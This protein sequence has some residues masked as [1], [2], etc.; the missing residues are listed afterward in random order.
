M[1][2]HLTVPQV[3]SWRPEVLV[4]QAGEWDRQATDLRTRVETQWRAVDSS[5]ETWQGPSGGAMRN[6]FDGVRTKAQQVLEA[7]EDGRD[8]A[9]VASMNF[10]TAKVVLKNSVDAAKAAGFDVWDDGTCIISEKTKQSVYASVA[11]SDRSGEAYQTAIAALSVS[12]DA[13]T[14]A[15]KKALDLAAEVDTQAQTAVRNA[16]ANMPAPDSFGNATTPKT[17]PAPPPPANGS[18][19]ENRAW[20][21]SLSEHEKTSLIDTRPAS[22]GGLDGLPDAVR[23]KANRNLIPIERARIEQDLAAYNSILKTDTT[24]G[25]ARSKR[26]DLQE[27]LDDLNEVDKQVSG[28]PERK[29]LLLDMRSGLQGRAA[30]AIGDPDNADHVSVTTPGLGTNVRESLGSMIGEAQALKAESEGQLNERHAGGSVATI[31]W[32]GY[33][34]PQKTYSDLDIAGVAM[35]GRAESAAPTLANFYEGLDVASTKNDPHITALGHSY[36]SLATSLALQENGRAV[37]D[38]VFYG[39]PGLG[40]HSPLLMPGVLLVDTPLGG[41]NDAVDSPEDLG[42][43]S[44]HVY[45]MTNDGDPIAHANR[46]GRSPASL[47]WVTHLSTDE[48]SISDEFGN[49]RTYTE[50]EGHAEYPRNGGNGLLHRSGYNLAAV[51]AGLPQNAMQ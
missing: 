1:S 49:E 21:D 35:E 38:V 26:D 25:Q 11:S 19:A 9:R 27:R 33:D 13:H 3:L 39:S 42:L 15:I 4:T 30:V 12:C 16:F 17:Q 31:A 40:G 46:F 28:Y 2:Q 47:P 18:P 41:L 5:H 37:D 32:I 45:E 34:P 43:S 29:L 7:L 44:G 8:A 23:D 36:G 10:T 22:V 24:N 50:G 51:V 6:R 14:A 20:W 48:I